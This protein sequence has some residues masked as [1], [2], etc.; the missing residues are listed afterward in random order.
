[1]NKQLKLTWKYF[2]KQKLEE[3]SVVLVGIFI[4]ISVFGLVA[5]FGWLP[6][7]MPDIPNICD[8][9]TV[10]LPS[11]HYKVPY[12]PSLPYWILITGLIT[13]S[14]WILIG[15]GYWIRCNWQIAKKRAIKEVKNG[16]RR[17]NKRDKK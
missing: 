4:I 9:K 10:A 13:T 15:I 5:Q 6:K 12:E 14:L 7:R 16:N 11:C 3:I 2:W 8:N 1:M 17:I